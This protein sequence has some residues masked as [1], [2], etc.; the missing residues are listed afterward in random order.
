MT[1]TQKGETK[2]NY[3]DYFYFTTH[4]NTGI[5]LHNSGDNTETQDL[6]NT[7]IQEVSTA[8]IELEKT[9]DFHQKDTTNWFLNTWAK[10]L[11]EH[12]DFPTNDIRLVTRS[13]SY[14]NSEIERLQEQG[15]VCEHITNMFPD[16]RQGRLKIHTMRVT[17]GVRFLDAFKEKAEEN[18][19][20]HMPTI[21]MHVTLGPKHKINVYEMP[22]QTGILILTNKAEERVLGRLLGSVWSTLSTTPEEFVKTADKTNPLIEFSKILYTADVD[23]YIEAMKKE[24]AA[25]PIDY[26]N[27]ER[28]KNLL[29]NWAE[30][31]KD[32]MK[33]QQEEQVREYKAR[34]NNLESDFTAATTELRKREIA[35]ANLINRAE[36]E[37]VAKPFI[38]YL[39]T[40][41]NTA[42]LLSFRNSRARFE[43]TTP[44]A[45]Y[46]RKDAAMWVKADKTKA[47]NGVN[48]HDI[49]RTVFTEVFD[50]RKYEMLTTTII[51]IDFANQR[52]NGK[53]DLNEGGNRTVIGNQHISRY[54][55]FTSSKK[56][57]LKAMLNED[58]AM[59]LAQIIAACA[60]MTFTD[61]P[62]V[63]ELAQVLRNQ[64]K[65]I[66]TFRNLE[67]KEI[68]SAEDILATVQAEE[69]VVEV[70]E[71]PNVIP[72]DRTTMTVTPTD[73]EAI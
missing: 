10:Y 6:I 46:R 32:R 47:S 54:D 68:V 42:K 39:I 13:N 29:T 57:A 62:V 66:K 67:T 60:T 25:N 44:I 52:I 28:L 11:C 70:A 55:C 24:I 53:S 8:Y 14:T 38:E 16:T 1:K 37:D 40:V 49:T 30:G 69:K 59:M 43:I 27:E 12:T 48:E 63:S 71:E 23:A 34:L 65:T 5:S 51:E 41:K 50:K 17:R 26:A 21:D 45:N 35:L 18:G 58:Y 19:F 7:K 64:G 9:Y 33:E 4:S 22:N 36:N 20:K 31:Q 72:P 3:Q 2:L 15:S 56:E 61:T 73:L